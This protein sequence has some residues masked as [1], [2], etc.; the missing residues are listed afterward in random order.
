M[1]KKIGELSLL[2][3][4]GFGK[5][6]PLGWIFF[7][8]HPGTRV[9]Y[10]SWSQGLS[11]NR[12][13]FRLSLRQLFLVTALV[14]GLLQLSL[15]QA[16]LGELWHRVIEQ[17]PKSVA[18]QMHAA[19]PGKANQGQLLASRR[20]SPALVRRAVYLTRVSRKS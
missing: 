19:I 5:L 15:H 10:D 8:H 9:Y 14:A 17:R 7:I 12:R 1:A 11:M 13:H 18:P 20:K 2:F 16:D 6:S 4:E 3:R